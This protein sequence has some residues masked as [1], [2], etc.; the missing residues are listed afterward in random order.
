MQIFLFIKIRKK[1][2]F[3][4]KNQYLPETVSVLVS[5]VTSIPSTL[6]SESNV[7]HSTFDSH[8]LHR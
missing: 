8:H 4:E 2:R 6:V 1:L 5:V 7:R 3:D